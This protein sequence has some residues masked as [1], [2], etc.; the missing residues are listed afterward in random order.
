[1][2]TEA[3][4][5]EHKVV[6]S[7]EAEE[8]EDSKAHQDGATALRNWKPSSIPMELG[9]KL[10]QL[11]MILSRKPLCNTYKGPTSTDKI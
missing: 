4:E 10:K 3:E 11:H 9:E 1:M 7:V 2:L 8:E 6:D 5:A